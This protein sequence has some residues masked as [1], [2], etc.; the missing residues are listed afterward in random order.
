VWAAFV[1]AGTLAAAVGVALL[2][3][4]EQVTVSLF[5]DRLT[6]GGMVLREVGSGS[7]ATLR[8]YDG[9]ASYVLAEHADGTVSAAAVW[10]SA[11]LDSSGLCKLRH[12]GAR[13]VEQCTFRGG[14]LHITSVDVLDPAAGPGWQRTYSDGAHATIA[15]GRFL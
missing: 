4:P 9:D 10:A 15:V 6:V 13:L 7:T 3:A 1:A 5:G 8:R 11:G 2:L 14:S 12:D